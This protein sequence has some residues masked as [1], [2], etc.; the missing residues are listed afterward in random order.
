LD[1]A[2]KHMPR[3]RALVE[4]ASGK[5]VSAI[6]KEWGKDLGTAQAEIS[7]YVMDSAHA[8]LQAAHGDRLEEELGDRSV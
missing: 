8:L 7:E 2:G 1:N 4:T 6:Q 5:L 3:K